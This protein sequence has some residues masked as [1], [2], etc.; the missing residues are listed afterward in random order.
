[1]NTLALSPQ[2]P[3]LPS[4][5]KQYAVNMSI[6]NVAVQLQL[7]SSTDGLSLH[8]VRLADDLVRSTLDDTASLG[9]RGA[10]AHEIGVDVTGGLTTFVNAPGYR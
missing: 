5:Y 3:S 7:R 1:M 6:R 4:Y 2:N 8:Q 9:K 10:D